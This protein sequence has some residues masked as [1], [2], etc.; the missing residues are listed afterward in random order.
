MMS[1]LLL[2]KYKQSLV[3]LVLQSFL[4]ISSSAFAQ[5]KPFITTWQVEPGGTVTIPSLSNNSDNPPYYDFSINW[6]DGTA[7]EQITSVDAN[8][9]GKWDVVIPSHTYNN[10][11]TQT[12]TIS[13]SGTFPQLYFGASQETVG[14]TDAFNRI[15]ASKDQLQTIEQW[16]DIEW[17][18]MYYA[19]MGCSN[20]H[21]INDA[22]APDFSKLTSTEGMFGLCFAL[23]NAS[24][25]SN[26]N[27]GNVTRIAQMFFYASK[28]NEDLSSWDISSLDNALAML[29][30]SGISSEN[31]D[32]LLIEW[33]KKV[34]AGTA[35][36]NIRFAAA[37]VKYCMG[38][39]ARQELIASGWGENGNITD[40]GSDCSAAF[41]T[42]WNIATDNEAIRI[43]INT[44]AEGGAYV[45][46]FTVDWGDG[47][48][49]SFGTRDNPS[50]TYAKAGVY[51]IKIS[52]NIDAD[53]DGIYEAGFPQIK[54]N[55][56]GDKDKILTVEQWGTTR[57]LNM[58]SAFMGCT[59]LTT[60]PGATPQEAPDLSE[61][62]N[63]ANMFS[64]C[65]N[66]NSN[67]SGWNISRG[68][69]F[70]QMFQNAIAFNN[71]SLEN[72]G[73]NPLTWTMK[74][75]ENLASGRLV[76]MFSSARSFNQSVSSWNVSGITDLSSMFRGA[77][78]FNNG[79]PENDGKNPLTWTMKD[80]ENLARGSLYFMFSGTRFNQNISSWN[81]S[82]I[83]SFQWM[84]SQSF[85]NNGSPEDDGQNPL[86]WTMKD[87][88]NLARGSF[89]GI[90]RISPF[91]QNISSWNVSKGTDFR[92]VFESAGKFNNGSITNDGANPLAWTMKDG[93]NLAGGSFRQTFIKAGSFNQN[94]SSWNVSKGTNFEQMFENAVA[95][96][97]GSVT[98]DGANPLA[99]VME[100]GEN[101]ASGRFYKTFEDATSFNQN[102]SSW[103]VSEATNFVFTFNNATKF[104]NGSV[105]NDAAN[106]LTWKTTHADATAPSIGI[107][108]TSMFSG[109]SSFNQDIST[110]D[111][112]GA[113]Y[114]S[115]MLSGTAL[116]VVNYDKF[117]L[118]LNDKLFELPKDLNFS[119]RGVKYCMGAQARLK[120]MSLGWGENGTILDGGEDCSAAFIT[121]WN[122]ASEDQS[123]TIPVINPTIPSF[124]GEGNDFYIDWGDAS[125]EYLT[126]AD[127]PFEHQYSTP[128]EYTVKI[129]PT[130]DN[131]G[132]GIAETGLPHIQCSNSGTTA[133]KLLSV[134]QWGKVQWRNM[135]RAYRGCINLTSVPGA[136]AG[137]GPNLSICTTLDYMFTGCSKL[138]SH[139]TYW[140][141]SNIESMVQTFDGAS[142]F[143]GNVSGW[144]IS[145][146]RTIQ[147][148]FLNA[149]SFNNGSTSNDQ[150]N[151]LNWV[152]NEH[153]DVTERVFYRTFMGAKSFN[154]LLSFED[155]GKVNSFG[156]MFS[157][158]T[159]FNQDLSSWDISNLSDARE[160]L[161]NC[162][163]S[164][165]NYDK[166]LIEW[167]KQVQAGTAASNITF[168]ARGL[169]FCA[170][171]KAR[172]ELIDS[173]WGDAEAG[174]QSTRYTD[175]TDAGIGCSYTLNFH[176][177]YHNKVTPTS[178]TKEYSKLN[179]DIYTF[180]LLGTFN[181]D[182]HDAWSIYFKPDDKNGVAESGV[183]KEKDLKM[184]IDSEPIYE[185]TIDLYAV[186]QGDGVGE[187]AVSID[188][189]CEIHYLK[190]EGSTELYGKAYVDRTAKTYLMDINESGKLFKAWA[191]ADAEATIFGTNEQGAQ[192]LQANALPNDVSV[193]KLYPQWIE[194]A[195]EADCEYYTITY[196]N[197]DG[198]TYQFKN[199]TGVVYYYQARKAIKLPALN[200]EG[201]FWSLTKGGSGERFAID[202]FTQGNLILYPT[203]K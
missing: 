137:S 182:E 45:Y 90:F 110:L 170:G 134:V 136:T 176:D 95:F 1:T 10:A 94:I 121:T 81:V 85:F 11:T 55:N 192:Y 12:Y 40:G 191:T 66:F 113:T 151:P 100:D 141:V 114:A 42:T 13:I 15:K 128:G 106:P 56:G 78:A 58:P 139:L 154:Q 123:L 159:V 107:G 46:D 131:D 162:G 145:K 150:R 198:T 97:N 64:G 101:I 147:G 201:T 14:N 18:A 185:T 119:A 181:H 158:A 187:P 25:V 105:T 122:I 169:N 83:T 44:S 161:D 167:N 93:E 59:N 92:N 69:D 197:N 79:S 188:D 140:D 148:M 4:F 133:E 57:W 104:N 157:G 115:D 156:L 172:R 116:S 203:S 86:T 143:N 160:M 60:V 73:A 31:Y 16:G 49:E 171:R 67:L 70:Y 2:R 8:A 129:M 87:G 39:R 84:F 168:S 174:D 111:L 24:S 63:F 118:A 72:D 109:A 163:M 3:L 20:L 179:N 34:Q 166:L 120:L 183:K 61:C 77:T 43:P 142:A 173:G 132:D 21:S 184:L 29:S 65:S 165:E 52:P 103:N 155:I 47:V 102:I 164:M 199:N 27:M 5:T 71:G 127:Y 175:I 7:V 75:G 51:A 200:I 41:I 91:N 76:S 74:D 17:G 30:F 54:F 178:Y 190:A 144:D 125:V 68:K 19:F 48:I 149:T 130:I 26:W 108:F 146:V 180:S 186:W 202:R 124:K 96:N 189:I 80:G 53:G 152:M 28:F 117:L 36:S 194:F 89:N 22:S 33:N 177:K 196:L 50:H 112:R 6:G 195:G 37:N 126:D 193:L 138:N 35:P 98:N 32:K 153:P 23:E 135:S 38:V 99:W 62:T 82:G 9:D 88:D